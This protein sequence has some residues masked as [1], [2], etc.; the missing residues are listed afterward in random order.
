[1]KK[2]LILTISLILVACSNNILNTVAETSYSSVVQL[3]P[4]TELPLPTQ[5]NTY[6]PNIFMQTP[7]S[8]NTESLEVPN[9]KTKELPVQNYPC[10]N[11]VTTHYVYVATNQYEYDG[12][13]LSNTL[14]NTSANF[15]CGALVNPHK[16]CAG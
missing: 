12:W 16:K 4:F 15:Y 7:K 3:D 9:L 11:V 14:N 8:T 2:L 6:M 13:W 5:K 1:M 10:Y